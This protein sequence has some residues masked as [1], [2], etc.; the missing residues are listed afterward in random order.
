MNWVAFFTF[1]LGDDTD[2]GKVLA[3][4]R[5]PVEGCDSFEAAYAKAKELLLGSFEEGAFALTSVASTGD[6]ELPPSD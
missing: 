1:N 3:T 2:E 6:I 4:S 5:F